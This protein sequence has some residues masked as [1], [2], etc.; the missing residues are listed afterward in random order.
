MSFFAKNSVVEDTRERTHRMCV[1]FTIVHNATPASKTSSSDMAGV[2]YLSTEGLT[3]AATAVDSGTTFTTETDST[4]VFGCLLA[5]MG[6]I[7]RLYDVQFVHLSSGT[8]T[9]TRVGSSST[10]LTA[11]NNIAVSIDW[12]GNLATTDLTGTLIVDYRVKTSK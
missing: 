11:S 4:G 9:V 10:G 1:P 12:S 5:N 2:L 7:D 6:T 3:A 8:A